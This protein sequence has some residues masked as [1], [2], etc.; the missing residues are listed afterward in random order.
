MAFQDG[1][2][3]QRHRLS[4]INREL[5]WHQSERIFLTTRIVLSVDSI[6]SKYN[7]AFC[8]R[9]H[10]TY[11]WY[12]VHISQS[13]THG[14]ISVPVRLAA[15]FSSSNVQSPKSTFDRQR[16]ETMVKPVTANQ[17]HVWFS[18]PFDF[19]PPLPHSH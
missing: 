5:L 14:E 11:T 6:L 8:T 4:R 10:S 12:T 17:P 3:G 9:P 7:S 16:E 1:R 13:W 19:D 18:P 2:H 15:F